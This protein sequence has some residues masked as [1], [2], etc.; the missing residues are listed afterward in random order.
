MGLIDDRDRL[1]KD[2]D[3]KKQEITQS[4]VALE[5][6]KLRNELDQ[7]KAEQTKIAKI[8]EEINKLSVLLQEKQSQ[9]AKAERELQKLK[10]DLNNSQQLLNGMRS[11]Q[12][13]VLSEIDHM[14]TSIRTLQSN[15][16]GGGGIF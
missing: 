11:R 13:A 3:A 8:N 15:L 5:G 12:G 10:H 4:E 16:G 1:Q 7:A 2:L 6:Y 14:T 9:I